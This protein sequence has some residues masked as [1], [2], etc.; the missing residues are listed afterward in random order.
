MKIFTNQNGFTYI[1][2]L[3]IVMIMGIMLGMVGQSWQL[4]KQRELEE[5]LLFRGDQVGEVIYQRLLCKKATLVLPQPAD[6]NLFWPVKSV[7]GTVLDDLVKNGLIE[8][9]SGVNTLFR[10]RPSAAIDPF[11]N[12]VWD[13]VTQNTPLPPLVPPPPGSNDRFLGVK[14]ASTSYPIMQNF[15]SIYAIRDLDRKLSH[16][17]WHF[18]WRLNWKKISP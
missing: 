18:T 8:S 12:N 6:L 4:I 10:L 14:S 13:F 15:S 3:T 2:A 7:N 17:D 1:L 5:E 16:S 9:C 11:T